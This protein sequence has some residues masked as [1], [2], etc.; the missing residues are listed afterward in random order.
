MSDHKVSE[1]VITAADPD[2][3]AGFVRRLISDR[4][5]SAGHITPIR[6]LYRWRGQLHDT[7]EVKATLHT[8]ASL[9]PAIIQRTRREHPYEVPCAVATPIA[10][11]N[12]DYIDWIISETISGD[13]V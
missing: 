3:L 7:T 11:A 13:L 6:S 8:R 1:V 4:L 2:W 9:V 5:C 10:D 12:P